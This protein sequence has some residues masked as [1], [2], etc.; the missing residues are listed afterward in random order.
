MFYEE[1]QN[2]A[3]S[4]YRSRPPWTFFEHKFSVLGGRKINFAE[5]SLY[6]SRMKE[7]VHHVGFWF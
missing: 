1:P 2:A 7:A 4:E 3:P 6:L 5:Q